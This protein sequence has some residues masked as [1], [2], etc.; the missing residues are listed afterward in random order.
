[1]NESHPQTAELPQIT[2]PIS[3]P[4]SLQTLVEEYNLRAKVGEN[5]ACGVLLKDALGYTL[6]YYAAVCVAACRELDCLPGEVAQIWSSTPSAEV[7]GKVLKECLERLL[8]RSE[9]LSRKLVQVFYEKD[10]E[11]RAFTTAIFPC[12]PLPE[13]HLQ[14]F[15]SISREEVKQL[16]PDL[17][18]SAAGILDAWIASSF[19]FF[20]ESEQRLETGAYFGQ[21]EQVVCFEQ[22]TLRTGLTMRVHESRGLAP[23]P[24][25]VPQSLV[26]LAADAADAA[27]ATDAA[28]TDATAANDAVEEAYGTDATDSAG[29][30]VDE[31]AQSEGVSAPPVSLKPVMEIA[32]EALDLQRFV[33]THKTESTPT[34]PREAP[35]KRLKAGESRL[36]I[37]LE[38]MGYTRNRL[39]KVGYG[40][41]LWVLSND[42][43]PVIGSVRATGGT[44]ELSPPLFEG[45]SNRIVYWVSADD[46]AVGKEYLEVSAEGEQR[47]YALWKLAPPSRFESL[48]RLKLAGLLLLPGTI[49]FLYS[50]WAFY[51]TERSME[52]QLRETLAA[53]YSLFINTTR[54]LSL[55]QAGIGELDVELRP[56]IESTIF[57]YLLVAWLVPVVVAK[58]FSQYPRRE[59]RALVIVFVLGSCLPLLAYLALW[60]SP[61]TQGDLAFHPELA[62]LDFRRS[63]LFFAGLN[64]LSTLYVMFSVEGFFH[65]FLNV[66]GRFALSTLVALLTGGVIL[67]RVYGSSWFG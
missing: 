26:A 62:L 41:F 9:R 23:L 13:F 58:L 6:R 59:Q 53:N 2:E 49:G 31:V 36:D 30:T 39:G 32:P 33:R 35:R 45:V 55:S 14:S 67:W 37:R 46:V 12:E 1:M 64:G 66:L 57:L 3:A 51:T 4:L 10:G 63:L 28:A 40:G 61:L 22:F 34:L 29:M 18:L 43:D 20:L 27:D 48:S 56:R 25:L 8:G 7:A 21:L 11:L 16:S 44:V 19:G 17:W 38:P 5:S 52:A 15:C 50:A 54:P 24:A 60:N 47:L 65:R 42:G